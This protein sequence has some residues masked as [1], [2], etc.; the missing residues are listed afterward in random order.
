VI[1]TDNIAPIINPLVRE[2]DAARALIA[3]PEQW[4]KRVPARITEHGVQRCIMGALDVVEAPLRVTRAI[5]A[6]IPSEYEHIPAFN[7]DPA[8]THA[9][10]LRVFDRARA[11]LL[12]GAP[13]VRP[14]PPPSRWR[15]F[16]NAI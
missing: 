9:D 10:V 7:D 8:T 14:E 13:L 5:E 1:T 6:V 16:L 3:M 15:R 12:S 2:L 11:L 4:C